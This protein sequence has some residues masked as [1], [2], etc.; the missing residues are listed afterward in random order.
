MPFIA[1]TSLC[2]QLLFHSKQTDKTKQRKVTL[3]ARLLVRVHDAH[4]GTDASVLDEVARK[5]SSLFASL[6]HYLDALAMAGGSG[7]GE[8]HSSG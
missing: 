8:G 2:V 4:E 3:D 6:T 7:G 5:T 1:T